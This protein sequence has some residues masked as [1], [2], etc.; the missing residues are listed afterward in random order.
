[1]DFARIYLYVLCGALALP[2]L[3]IAIR[4][5]CLSIEPYLRVR[6]TRFR[7]SKI[8]FGSIGRATGLQLLSLALYFAVNGFLLGV[9]IND[10]AELEQRAAAMASANLMLLFLGG[11]TNALSDFAQIPLSTYFFG[12]RWIGIVTT[13]E[14]MAHSGLALSHHQNLD[15]LSKSGYIVSAPISCENAQSNRRSGCWWLATDNPLIFILAKA[16]WAILRSFSSIM[17]YGSAQRPCLAYLPSA[18]GFGQDTSVCI[19]RVI[20]MH[21]PL[22]VDS[23]VHS[24]PY[25]R[26]VE[27]DMG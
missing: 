24:W 15:A 10:W 21:S 16:I 1:M 11:R 26:A 8:K 22:Q 20:D 6:A 3:F 12:H 7:Y 5:L 27:E 18:I 2:V 25:R 9:G 14:A 17:L 19:L 4:F 23:Y 13:C